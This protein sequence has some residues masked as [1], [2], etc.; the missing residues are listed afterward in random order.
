MP[1]LINEL[2]SDWIMV[3]RQSRPRFSKRLSSREAR[4]W[5]CS[6]NF[7]G[8]MSLSI[9]WIHEYRWRFSSIILIRL[10]E[11]MRPTDCVLFGS[12]ASHCRSELEA[13]IGNVLIANAGALRTHTKEDW[14]PLKSR[15]WRESLK[16]IKDLELKDLGIKVE[17]KSTDEESESSTRINIRVQQVAN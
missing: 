2:G 15:H 5:R 10:S 7:D 6:T 12:R 14:S 1:E 13:L 11:R 4:F 9:H 17:L 3:G 8:P 16:P